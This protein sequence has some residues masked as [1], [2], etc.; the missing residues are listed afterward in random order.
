MADTLYINDDGIKACLDSITGSAATPIG[1]GKLRLFKNNI[2]VSKATVL[3]NLTEATF[4][5]YA[6]ITLASVNWAAATVSGHLA[7]SVDGV[8]HVF[9]RSTTGAGETEYGWYITD[10][11][12]TKLYAC[13]LFSTG[14]FTVT[15]SG[16]T[17]TVNLTLTD[18]SLN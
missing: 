12:N 8:P 14:P 11:G 18:Q 16:D 5:G 9:T 4:A 7:T 10:A 6:A 1:A 3:A 17:I 2:A 15:N 13:A